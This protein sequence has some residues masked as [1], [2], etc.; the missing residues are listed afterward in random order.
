MK[1]KIKDLI[2]KFNS[3]PQKFRVTAIV[4]TAVVLIGLF[5][6]GCVL[7]GNPIAKIRVI[8]AANDYI[9]TNMPDMKRSRSICKYDITRD[10]YY[11]DFK[12]EG[13]KSAF[14]LEFTA[15]GTLTKDGYTI[16]YVYS[17]MDEVLYG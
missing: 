15:D 6:G 1:A 2:K 14:T 13:W 7:L 4:I 17:N 10:I 3:K 11:I 8:N 9:D 5:C 12:P 16:E